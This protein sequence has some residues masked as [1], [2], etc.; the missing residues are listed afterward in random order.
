LPFSLYIVVVGA[1]KKRSLTSAAVAAAAVVSAKEL[2]EGR[3]AFFL[4]F[5]LLL[6]SW[7]QAILDGKM[8]W[9]MVD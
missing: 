4:P 2:G 3:R 6:V 9:H 5:L 7:M 1:Y 8:E